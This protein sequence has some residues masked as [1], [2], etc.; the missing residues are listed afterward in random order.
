MCWNENISLNTFIFGIAVLIF[1]YYNNKYTQYKIESFQNI[2][3]YVLFIS[4]IS[5]QLVEY[6]LWKSINQKNQSMNYLWSVI[7]WLTIRVV[8]PISFLL[9][10]PNK[11]NSLRTK[12]IYIYLLIFSLISIY[13]YKYN[14]F[15]FETTVKNGHLYWKWLSDCT[16]VDYIIG[17]FYFTFIL[18]VYYFSGILLF[19]ILLQFAY[20]YLYKNA[21]WGSLWCWSF[22]L[23]FLYYLCKILF[24][25][26]F[27]EYNGL[28]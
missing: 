17:I 18:S 6:F 21:N 3:S 13:E 15:N 9:M 7:G 25:M 11:Y 19:L 24:I 4:I 22:N 10:L 5:M 28:C 2:Y 1:I 16:L 14:L 8:Q 27:N 20:L 23:I 12:F 26:P